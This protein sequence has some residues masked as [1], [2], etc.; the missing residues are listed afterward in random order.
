MFEISEHDD[1]LSVEKAASPVCECTFTTSLLASK[2][3]R[4]FTP[5]V[6]PRRPEEDATY[7]NMEN[8]NGI[9]VERWR[10]GEGERPESDMTPDGTGLTM[11]TDEQ[12]PEPQGEGHDYSGGNFSL[13]STQSELDSTPSIPDGE[14]LSATNESGQPEPEHEQSDE[15]VGPEIGEL[16]PFEYARH[17]ELVTNHLQTNPFAT[18]EYPLSPRIEC[19]DL[20]D[21]KTLRGIDDLLDEEAFLKL[22]AAEKLDVD[23]DTAAFLR[24]MLDLAP[25]TDDSEG[26]R[27][28]EGSHYLRNLKLEEPILA[29]DPALDLWRLRKRNAITISS[30]GMQPFDIDEA[31]GEGLVWSKEEP[32]AHAEIEKLVSNEKLDI[33]IDTLT[34]LKDEILMLG[35][36]T[37]SRDIASACLCDR[38]VRTSWLPAKNHANSIKARIPQH[39]SSP[40]LLISPPLSPFT[41]S[42]V[43]INLELTSS[44]ADLTAR[45]ASRLEEEILQLEDASSVGTNVNQ[46]IALNASLD[47]KS[48]YSPLCTPQDSSSSPWRHSKLRD[49]EVDVPLIP[50]KPASTPPKKTKNVS[51]PAVVH[52]MIPTSNEDL[53]AKD[54]EQG[55]DSFIEQVVTPL[56]ESAIQEAENERLSE[57]DTTMRVPVPKVE[58][59]ELRTPW[60]R[61]IDKQLRG[62]LQRELLSATEKSL[63]DS[64]KKWSGVSK[65]ERLLSW[66]P[67]PT[68]LG[69]VQADEN[70][71]DGSLARYMAEITFEDRAD[72]EDLVWKAEGL[73]ILDATDSDDE[74][75]EPL[76][77]DGVE[78][79][80]YVNEGETWTDKGQ[81]APQPRDNSE[82]TDIQS[83]GPRPMDMQTLLRKRK[84][85][86][87]GQKEVVWPNKH[88]DRST[89]KTSE[90]RKSVDA[91]NVGEMSAFIHLHGGEA[92]AANMPFRRRGP[93]LQQFAPLAIMVQPETKKKESVVPACLP[94]PEIVRRG[95]RKAIVVS[96]DLSKNRAL[97][98]MILKTIP[99]IEVVEREVIT[100][101]TLTGQTTTKHANRYEADV[102]VSPSTGVVLTTVQ[103]LK[104]KPLPGQSAFF[105]VR[106]RIQSVAARYEKFH[107]LVSEGALRLND[108]QTVPGALVQTDAEALSD[109]IG[110]GTTLDADVEVYYIPGGEA[111]LAQWAASLISRYSVSEISLLQ[112]ETLWERFLRYAGL[113]SY[114]SQAILGQLKRVEGSQTEMNSSSTEGLA[115]PSNGLAAFVQMTAEKR[116]ERFGPLMGGDRVL[117]RVNSVM[118]N[119]WMSAANTKR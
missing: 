49:L 62:P 53:H 119:Q 28:I 71:D 117:C 15:D 74:E 47:P 75:L 41:R 104:Q 43:A 99:E 77:Q 44:P 16:S 13:S 100:V 101:S 60:K 9:L 103:Q 8:I 76:Q 85:E 87:Q 57:F 68:R 107:V 30:K 61:P 67:F 55:L 21:P 12:T 59:I 24:S 33:D 54:L 80:H 66:S 102:T 22:N 109:F 52:T 110:F 91:V 98:R 1:W 3:P 42:P 97:L 81:P 83:S 58:H 78:E 4:P 116:L 2:R 37:I 114:A 18:V 86:L 36:S 25:G 63:V 35:M 5:L 34:Y 106:D 105:G 69:K 72:L 95:E 96:S 23:K 48:I 108:N 39:A 10:D 64:D 65:V 118:D 82:K 14:A 45:E 6:S 27:Q 29:S 20:E 46:S 93:T 84:L 90:N 50:D 111:E 17:Y 7:E 11:G 88:P 113:N 70:F 51:F 115:T 94:A 40:L 89:T 79:L 38:P 92:K 19:T 73:R 31:K 112:E 32:Y 26:L 56:A